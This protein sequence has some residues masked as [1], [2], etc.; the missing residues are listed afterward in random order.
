MFKSWIK[1][2]NNQYTKY[3]I[4]FLKDSYFIHWRPHSRTIIH[5]HN[6]K[7]CEFIVFQY[8]LYECLYTEKSLSS[9]YL[10][11]ELEPLKKYNV[12]KDD[13]HQMLNLDKKEVWS[14][15]KYY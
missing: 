9:L 4:P 13:Y 7:N 1:N 6:D 15:H 12:K 11:R 10:S 2:V 8:K 3:K 14:Y 5:N